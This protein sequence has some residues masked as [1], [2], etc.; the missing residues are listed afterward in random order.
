MANLVP[1][2]DLIP[3]VERIYRALVHLHFAEADASTRNITRYD[4]GTGFLVNLGSR[5]FVFTA[6]H[7]LDGE[8]P[9]T[10]GV[11]IPRE[12]TIPLH[13]GQGVRRFFRAEGDVDA[14]VV[15]LD[16]A[17]RVLWQSAQPFERHE[18]G[19]LAES[20]IAR[21]LCLCGFPV[22]ERL[23]QPGLPGMDLVQQ[24]RAT[25]Q[26]VDEVPDYKSTH[27]PPEGRGIHV[28]YGG[29]AY[30]HT[31]KEW[32]TVPPPQGIS[33]GPLV[34]IGNNSVRVLAVARS[35]ENGVEWCE[36]AIECTRLL[37]DHD[38]PL[39]AAEALAVVRAASPA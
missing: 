34:A 9:A 28:R 17:E 16:P 39:V 15:E 32:R 27:E 6:K 33:G 35:I 8:T 26:L 21:A 2:A 30:D 20:R 31:R 36:P 10:T 18:L 4:A 37:L 11:Q 23:A 1:I 7:N 13:F 24:F 12:L 14:A 38:D 29:Q 19:A 5:E 25:M 22:A 3:H